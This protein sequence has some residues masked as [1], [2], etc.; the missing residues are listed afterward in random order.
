MEFPGKDRYGKMRCIHLYNSK[1]EW[2]K[3]YINCVE[4]MQYGFDM[5]LYVVDVS[6][7]C[8]NDKI[9][10]M[11]KIWFHQCFVESEIYCSKMLKVPLWILW[12]MKN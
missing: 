12:E 6:L 8:N 2:D 5:M 11:I 9:E 10:N 7:F 1:C 4:M 3:Q